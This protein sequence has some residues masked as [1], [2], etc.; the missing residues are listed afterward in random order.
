MNVI[1]LLRAQRQSFSILS[2]YHKSNC[3][4]RL[5][6]TIPSYVSRSLAPSPAICLAF[7]SDWP[8][9][10]C[11]CRRWNKPE[12]FSERLV[13]CRCSFFAFLW[14]YFCSWCMNWLHIYQLCLCCS[15]LD[16][17]ASLISLRG[18]E[19]NLHLARSLGWAWGLASCRCFGLW[20]SRLSHRGLSVPFSCLSSMVLASF[21]YP[22]GRCVHLWPL[23]LLPPN[24]FWSDG[25][26]APVGLLDLRR[27]RRTCS[28]RWRTFCFWGLHL[29][30][31]ARAWAA[32]A[33]PFQVL[34]LYPSLTWIYSFWLVSFLLLYDDLSSDST[35]R[36]I[37]DW[38]ELAS[39]AS[40]FRTSNPAYLELL[41]QLQSLQIEDGIQL[42]RFGQSFCLACFRY[43]HNLEVAR[44]R[45]N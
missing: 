17:R 33:W 42:D 32:S 19:R 10:A 2:H 1:Y 8:A 40:S 21:C 37:A 4:C 29:S 36:L 25:W 12:L 13:S 43:H 41:A 38:L 9:P 27:S 18:P 3:C 16:R 30:S 28:R 24:W 45:R 6:F 39:T 20:C 22:W 35:Q 31:F 23:V 11:R 26:A 14:F 7:L 5:P 34:W 15:H 44:C